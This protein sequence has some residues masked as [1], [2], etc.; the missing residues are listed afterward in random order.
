[1]LPSIQRRLCTQSLKVEVINR[2]MRSQ[3]HDEWYAALGLR[4][5]EPRRV[6]DARRSGDRNINIAPLYE[7]KITNEDVLNFWENNY[8]DQPTKQI[9]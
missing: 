4:Y 3:G 2:F 1:M 7:Q 6:S 9:S 5:D 8:F